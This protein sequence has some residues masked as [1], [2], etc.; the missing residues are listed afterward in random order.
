M[1]ELEPKYDINAVI[2]GAFHIHCSQIAE[3][4]LQ[5]LRKHVLPNVSKKQNLRMRELRVLNCIYRFSG[6]MT[7]TDI[8]LIMRY[9]S[10]TV[11]RALVRLDAAGMIIKSPNQLDAR[12]TIV[13]LS[14]K[15][16]LLAQEY[17]NKALKA[18]EVLGDQFEQDLSE[19]EIEQFLA[20]AK[21]IAR[22]TS[23]MQ[24]INALPMHELILD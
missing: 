17:R 2:D 11:S 6:D 16:H 14:D 19:H 20:I 22:R 7:A 8:A 3:D 4:Y 12:A 21:K 5:I 18:Y 9:D 23:S 1:N 15:G 10:A 24:K 13:T